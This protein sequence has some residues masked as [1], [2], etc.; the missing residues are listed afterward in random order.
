MGGD[1]TVALVGAAPGAARRR[2]T[3]QVLRVVSWAAPAVCAALAVSS[4]GGARWA[5]GSGA[6][7]ATAV[8]CAYRRFFADF[9]IGRA[10]CRERV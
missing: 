1:V 3:V 8:A 4:G 10:S 7:V 6:V 2:A 5:F 9:E